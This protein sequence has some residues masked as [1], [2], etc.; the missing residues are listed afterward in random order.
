[1]LGDLAVI[2]LLAQGVWAVVTVVFM[3]TVANRIDRIEKHA[4]RTVDRLG[5]LCDLVK[6]NAEEG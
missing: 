2:M 3:A 4:K 6:G 5:E 1:M